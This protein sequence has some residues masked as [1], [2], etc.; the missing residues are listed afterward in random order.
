ML[1]EKTKKLR[2]EVGTT[3]RREKNVPQNVCENAGL[4]LIDYPGEL[5]MLSRGYEDLFTAVEQLAGHEPPLVETCPKE[6]MFTMLTSYLSY[7][8]DHLTKL[9]GDS[10]RL[11][12]QVRRDQVSLKKMKTDSK[13]RR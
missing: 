10:R 7:V 9:T 12:D 4:N 8:E 6:P 1:I 5:D 13:R 3:N 2:R 11:L